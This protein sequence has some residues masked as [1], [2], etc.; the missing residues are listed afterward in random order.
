LEL[1]RYGNRSSE[2]EITKTEGEW[3]KVLTPEQFY[4]LRK[5]GTE[6]PHTS[7]LISSM[8]RARIVLRVTRH[9]SSETKFN[10]GTGWPLFLPQLKTR[11]PQP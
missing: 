2:F 7:Q 5:H 8:P 3:R 6:R 11:P 4:V 10:S 1:K 9:F